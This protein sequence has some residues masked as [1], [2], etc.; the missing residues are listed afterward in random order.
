MHC[1]ILLPAAGLAVAMTA[2]SALAW[3]ESRTQ[4][5]EIVPADDRIK[6]TRKIDEGMHG[7]RIKPELI[8]RLK[9]E[10][11]EKGFV[12]VMDFP[13]ADGQTVQ[14][15]LR[16]ANPIA[17]GAK[18][19]IRSS[20][21]PKNAIE[22]PFRVP[23][24]AVVL[25]GNVTGEP[26]SFAM[27]ALWEK[28]SYGLIQSSRG[29]S[30][31]ASGMPG[32]EFEPVIYDP[33]TA[34]GGI[35]EMM[36]WS[37]GSDPGDRIFEAPAHDHD[38]DHAEAPAGGLAGVE[39]C[40]VI[41]L[42]LEYDFEFWAN[43]LNANNENAF[44]YTLALAAAMDEIYRRDVGIG[45]QISYLNVWTAAD[46]PW[47]MPDT[48]SQLDELEIWY[49]ANGEDVDRDAVMLCS[50]RPLGGG[51]ANLDGLCN[52]L[53]YGVS[54]GMNGFF[55]Y[56]LSDYAATNWDI[57]V[58][59]HELGHIVGSP[60]THS[61]C[62]PL[63]QCA[64]ILFFGT[65]Q[66]QQV[67]AQG[68]L[69]GYCHLCPGGQTNVHL[70]FHPTTAQTIADYVEESDC[71]ETEPSEL[72]A[73]DDFAETLMNTDVIIDVLANDSAICTFPDIEGMDIAST[74]GGT[75]YFSTGSGPFGRTEI[76]FRPKTGFVGTDSFEYLATDEL[77]NLEL[78]L[79]TIEVNPQAYQSD[80]LVID[81]VGNVVQ[82]FDW[83]TG[84]FLGTLVPRDEG[85]VD[86]AYAAC[87]GP[88]ND[89]MVASFKNDFVIRYEQ[90]SGIST[91]IIGGGPSIDGPN[92]V[93]S[94]VDRAYVSARDAE[95]VAAFDSDANQ[96]AIYPIGA[97][98]NDI[99]IEPAEDRLLVAWGATGS[100][101]GVLTWN[102]QTNLL[103][104]AFL[105]THLDHAVAVCRLA[106]GDLLVA[107]GG[108][109]RIAR[110]DGQTNAFLGWFMTPS[111]SATNEIGRLQ[112]MEAG[113][114]GRIYLTSSTGLHRLAAN[115]DF[116]LTLESV[117]D[118]LLHAPVG[119]FF[120]VGAP[121]TG[122]LNGDG[123]INGADL[124]VILGEWGGAGRGDLNRDGTIDGTDLAIILGNWS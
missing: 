110:Y 37:C 33:D 15:E 57:H 19:V 27:L 72:Q 18:F 1:S 5:D 52:D 113:P 83:E 12:Q 119:L 69:M 112:R 45:I 13:L 109:S 118:G 29:T 92:D 98:P 121:L 105:T 84:A 76:R 61:Y 22:Q 93:V 97:R 40:R 62:P 54:A 87:H 26:G 90:F 20:K 86:F 43:A 51:I 3:H 100:T 71:I 28:A 32:N 68:T 44:F 14:L 102:T 4:T 101:S 114:G 9:N 48:S 70:G 99:R 36:P 50:G 17:P 46:D 124:A 65:C 82:R 104:D 31:I 79:V 25:T 41:K 117:G 10:A 6:L 34:L 39:E 24:G 123:R 30:V 78:A 7:V 74:H 96:I 115:G 59:C 80:L 106:S 122:D 58:M 2:S 53:G 21:D 73:K 56:P 38:H 111:D 16:E 67:C 66:S 107:D 64:P 108:T 94:H 55:T 89:L 75:M 63:D 42:A 116:E 91:G 103:S 8:E 60:H 85:G 49:A 23:D 47:T 35:L 81:P 11:R 95:Q 77:G 88:E 120:R